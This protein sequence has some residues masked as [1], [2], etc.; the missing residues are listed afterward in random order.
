MS[1]RPLLDRLRDD[2]P[3]AALDETAPQGVA[4]DAPAG[5]DELVAAIQRAVAA[6]AE[7]D[8]T[9]AWD[10]AGDAHDPETLDGALAVV[11]PS[12]TVPFLGGR[13]RRRLRDSARHALTRTARAGTLRLLVA[14]LGAVGT[15]EDVPPLELVAAHPALTLHGATA[16]A[17]LQ[18]WEGRAAL[19]RLLSR[20]DG[21]ARVVVI[22]RLLP[23]VREPAVRLALVR[24]AFRG[25]DDAH[26]RAIA[27]AVADCVDLR[28]MLGDARTPDELRR[29]AEHVLDLARTASDAEPA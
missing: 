7:S 27:P 13:R 4:R 2:G 12:V 14:I 9:S 25:L 16:L 1:T 22:D 8:G 24:D 10:A 3:G 26:A 28:A 5:V 17:N 29:C 20:T 19:L 11:A 23:F 18:H 6:P 15:Q 21:D